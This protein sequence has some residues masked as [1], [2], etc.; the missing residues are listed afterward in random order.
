MIK[1]AM[2]MRR[3]S[4]ILIAGALLLSLNSLSLGQESEKNT[5]PP[6]SNLPVGVLRDPFWAVGWQPPGWAAKAETDPTV[7]VR[8]ISRWKEARKLI[9]ITGIS[10][11]P[12]GNN[13]VAVLRGIGVVEAGDKISVDYNGLAYKWKVTSITQN[14]IATEQIGVFPVK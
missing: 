1:N 8:E 10:K 5:I 3:P 7:N 9:V 11:K 14:G 13:Y 2:I 6:S 4:I 12:N